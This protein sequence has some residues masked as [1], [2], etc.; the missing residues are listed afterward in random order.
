MAFLH[1]EL[2][3]MEVQE[4]VVLLE[5]TGNESRGKIRLKRLRCCSALQLKF[6]WVPLQ[7]HW[8]VRNQSTPRKQ[9]GLLISF[10]DST[11]QLANQNVDHTNKIDC[12]CVCVCVG[13][14]TFFFDLL[15]ISAHHALYLSVSVPCLTL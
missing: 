7:W 12:V 14:V 15:M 10:W 13:G 8:N 4:M 9:F 3:Q 5:A 1:L 6:L 11:L 2:L